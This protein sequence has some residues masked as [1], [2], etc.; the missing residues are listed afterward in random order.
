LSDDD[1]YNHDNG[2]SGLVWDGL[3]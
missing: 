3:G 1:Y 2:L